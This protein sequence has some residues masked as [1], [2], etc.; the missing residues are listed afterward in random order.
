M[1]FFGP[2]VRRPIIALLALLSTPALVLAAATEV[3]NS[4]GAWVT[5]CRL[6]GGYCTASSRFPAGA[7][8]GTYEYL[9][10]VSRATPEAAPEIAILIAGSRPR[11][12][13]PITVQVD[14]GTPIELA[15]GSG[16]R[17]LALGGTYILDAGA[18]ATLLGELRKG[19]RVEFRY[20]TQGAPIAKT[21]NLTGFREAL[22]FFERTQGS[23]LPA[24]PAK[25]ASAPAP[26]APTPIA[27]VPA[28]P[29]VAQ[30]ETAPVPVD[31]RPA[32]PETSPTPSSTESLPNPV[33]LPLPPEPRKPAASATRTA[34]SPPQIPGRRRVAKLIRQFTC[35]ASEPFWNLSIDNG[36]ARFV[37]LSGSGE[38]QA[39]VLV[40]K[41]GITG[42]G[43]TPDV[44]WR[45]K[46]DTGASYRALIN[47]TRCVDSA[48][49]KDAQ[50]QY[51]Y[52]VQITMPGGK[53][54]RGCCNAGLDTEGPQP[55]A[56]VDDLPVADLKSK[57][58]DDWTRVLLDLLPA[59]QACLDKTPGPSAYVTKAWPMNRGMVGARTR[60]RDGG[61]FEC[62]ATS[63][64]QSVEHIE[65]LPKAAAPLPGEQAAVFTPAAQTP[66]PG[67]C[68][69]TERVQDATGK[70]V[71]W[72]S[73]N[74]C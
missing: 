39:V 46:S 52:R 35:R 74:G 66:P 15:A 34:Q 72:L 10:R 70:M 11:V 33:P 8:G 51:D 49:D 22:A 42:E 31:T 36:N 61:W 54:L 58:S 38:P 26:T 21:F 50:T 60:N 32:R 16:Y 68:Y 59:M 24:P 2:T 53:A 62:I 14:Q 64:G 55:P 45:G 5:V 57:A 30:T 18:A 48:A 17:A 71:G 27:P 29:V 13:A 25:I 12:D 20:D 3:R 43:R 40:G 1:R 9:L 56:G 44:D 73:I 41:L 23:A 19:K 4:T 69:R 6:G 37:T 47:E 67:N 28:P 63:D 65:M 7:T